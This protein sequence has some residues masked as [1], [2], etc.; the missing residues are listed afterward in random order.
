MVEK[1]MAVVAGELCHQPAVGGNAGSNYTPG[2][3][4][5]SVNFM[6]FGFMRTCDDHSAGSFMTLH[7]WYSAR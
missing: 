5:A 1:G 4:L 3:E 6:V 7:I 2:H